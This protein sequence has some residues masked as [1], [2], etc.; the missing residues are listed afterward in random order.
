[1]FNFKLITLRRYT[2]FIL[3]FT[4][5]L[6]VFITNVFAQ[7]YVTKSVPNN[8]GFKAYMSYTAITNKNSA[9][10]KLQQKATTGEYGIRK[11]GDRYCIALGS[12]YTTQIGTK[13][14]VV[15]KNGNVVK[16]ILGDVKANIHTD[17]TNRANPNGCVVEFLVDMQ[18]LNNVCRKMGNMSYVPSGVLK[19]EIESIRVYN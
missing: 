12:Y 1:M 16:C 11:V 10:Y 18:R 5:C 2:T 6:S 4:L 3:A 14:D 9:Q 19:G 15:M 8:N 17:S 7:G 13:V